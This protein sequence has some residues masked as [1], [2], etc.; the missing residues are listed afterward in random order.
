MPTFKVDGM[1]CGGCVRGVT[2]AIQRVDPQST[3]HV[4]LA[5]KTVEVD[6]T[7]PSAQIVAAIKGAGFD[8]SE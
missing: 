4:D 3:V 7:L 1:T 5:T 8:V 2:N 6:S